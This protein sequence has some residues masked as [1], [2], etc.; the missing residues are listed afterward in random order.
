MKTEEEIIL[1]INNI[2]NKIAS[3]QIISFNHNTNDFKKINSSVNI[4]N[5]SGSQPIVIFKK[6]SK[7]LTQP[8]NLTKKQKP[9]KAVDNIIHNKK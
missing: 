9:S 3:N 7:S 6:I 1:L 4:I 5:T 2:Q 8:F